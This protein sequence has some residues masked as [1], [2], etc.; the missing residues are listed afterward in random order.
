MPGGGGEL[1]SHTRKGLLSA[2]AGALRTTRTTVAPFDSR[3]AASDPA[4]GACLFGKVRVVH[5]RLALVLARD[6]GALPRMLPPFRF[7][8]GASLGPGTR[9]M[10][11]IALADVVRAIEFIVRA[12]EIEGAVNLVAPEQVTNSAFTAALAKA[13]HRPALL[14]VPA[15]ALTLFAGEMAREMFLVSQRA[16]PARLLEH[17]FVFEQPQLAPTLREL[18]R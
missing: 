12:P 9:Y 8:V 6:G 4:R 1:K 10:S 2:A 14:K 3:E 15:F 16:Y 17:G 13:L 7:G 11:W 18:L 5:L